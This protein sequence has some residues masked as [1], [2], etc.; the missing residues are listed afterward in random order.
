MLLEKDYYL[1]VVLLKLSE[2]DHNLIFKGGTCLNKCY[3]GYYRL[4]EDLDF[5]HRNSGAK[6]RGAR[7]EDFKKT[8]EVINTI[9]DT[10]PGMTCSPAKKFDEHQQL[11]IDINYDSFFTNNASI[12]FEVTHRYAL[13]KNPLV[14][15]IHHRFKHPVTRNLYP[16]TGRIPCID[17]AEAAA[18]KVRACLTRRIPAIRDFFDLCFIRNNSIVDTSDSVFK[19][20]V[21]SK[22]DET[23]GT[24]DI[25]ASIKLLEKQLDEVLKPMLNKDYSFDLKDTIKFAL[26]FIDDAV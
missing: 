23:S 24:T 12:K 2:T 5:I 21:Q 20:L 13:F 7:E 17:I 18:E 9:V 26:T 16:D 25:N 4:S 3:L 14:K 8:D 6:N 10:L 22:I 11:R 1:T 19:K 15:N